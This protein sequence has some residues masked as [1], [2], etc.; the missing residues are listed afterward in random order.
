MQITSIQDQLGFHGYRYQIDNKVYELKLDRVIPPLKQEIYKDSM[1]E[2]THLDLSFFTIPGVPSARLRFK[3]PIVIPDNFKVDTPGSQHK[4]ESTSDIQFFTVNKYIITT[5]QVTAIIEYKDG[6]AQNAVVKENKMDTPIVTINYDPYG[7]PSRFRVLKGDKIIDSYYESTKPVY[8]TEL[9]KYPDN[10][11]L[12]ALKVYPQAFT[13]LFN[14]ILRTNGRWIPEA[15]GYDSD[16]QLYESIKRW[17]ESAPKQVTPPAQV[18]VFR[19]RGRKKELTELFNDA[20]IQWRGKSYLDYGAGSGEIA[21]NLGIHMKF[22]QP[23]YATDIEQWHGVKR[24]DRETREIVQKYLIN[25]R[26]PFDNKKFDIITVLMVLHHLPKLDDSVNDILS[27]LNRN[28]YLVIREHD[29]SGMLTR[30]L[31]HIEHALYSI[32]LEN[33]SYTEFTQEYY[34]NYRS[35][36][37]WD[38]YLEKYPLRKI[39][40][41]EPHGLTRYYYSVWMKIG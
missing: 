34:G 9:G 31:C 36:E 1:I 11:A 19:S 29:V 12:W 38:S 37:E 4:L 28:G 32:V 14:K 20:K 40:I 5:D 7:Y 25:G 41:T 18:E 35:V 24:G 15:K 6:I 33:Q 27:H 30:A 17:Y 21:R 16:A 23:V 26:I 13:E 3:R 8:S 2:S 22:R 10:I 39:S